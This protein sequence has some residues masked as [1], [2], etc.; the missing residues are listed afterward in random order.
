M[1]QLHCA[2]RKLDL[3]ARKMKHLRIHRVLCMH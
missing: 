3:E 1:H 2:Y